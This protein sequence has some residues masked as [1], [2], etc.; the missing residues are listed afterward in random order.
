MF[1]MLYLSVGLFAASHDHSREALSGH[2]Q[3]D[4][5]A[6][7]HNSQFDLP[8]SEPILFVPETVR[9]EILVRDIPIVT[10]VVG[11]ASTRGPP[12]IP[13]S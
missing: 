10:A 13:Q 8:G 2:Q 1:A 3:C 7:H 12:F 11:I 5:C 6:W 9:S 4:A